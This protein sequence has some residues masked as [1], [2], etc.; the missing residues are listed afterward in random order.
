MGLTPKK[1]LL[2]LQ[3]TMAIPLGG[4]QVVTL[5]NRNIHQSLHRA[6]LFQLVVNMGFTIT[7]TPP[8]VIEMKSWC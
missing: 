2:G 3:P 7:F 8:K 1:V 5:E 6:I 4:V